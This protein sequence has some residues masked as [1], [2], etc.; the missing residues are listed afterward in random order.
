MPKKSSSDGS[1]EDKVVAAKSDVP[2]L[3][4]FVHGIRDPGFWQQKLRTMFEKERFV[5]VPIGYGVLDVFRFLLGFRRKSVET[6][7]TQILAAM[8]NNPGSQVTI[9]AHSFG[10]YA[11]ARLLEENPSI[12]IANLVMCGAIVKRGYRWDKTVNLNAQGEE[13][14]H[15]VNE[16]SARDV[17]P[18]IARHATFGFGDVGSIGCQDANVTDRRHNLPHSA[19]L[20]ESFAGD[21]WVGHLARGEKLQ[22]SEEP[23][24]TPWYFVLTRLP[25]TLAQAV[26]VVATT[27]AIVWSVDRLTFHTAGEL[28]I[29]SAALGSDFT[30]EGYSKTDSLVGEP[31]YSIV[32]PGLEGTRRLLSINKYDRIDV[33]IKNRIPLDCEIKLVANEYADTPDPQR[34]LS[35]QAVFSIS[36]RNARRFFGKAKISFEYIGSKSPDVGDF[37]SGAPAANDV[38]SKALKIDQLIIKAGD[39]IDYR[40]IGVNR[41][42]HAGDDCLDQTFKSDAFVRIVPDESVSRSWFGLLA[43]AQDS[44]GESGSNKVRQLLKSRDLQLRK[45]GV[46]TVLADPKH[47]GSDVIA[48]INSGEADI[49]TVADLLLAA[50]S[51]GTENIKLDPRTVLQLTYSDDNQVRD[52]ARS[53][54]RKPGIVSDDV[55][56]MAELILVDKLPW[57][58]KQVVEGKPFNKDYLLLIAVRDIYYNIGV[59]KLSKHLDSPTGSPEALRSALATF[60]RGDDLMALAASPEQRAT[61]SKNIYGRA[62]AEYRGAIWAAAI[63][64]GNPDAFLRNAVAE[65]EPLA[66]S[67]ARQTFASFLAAVGE[68]RAAYPWPHHIAQAERCV[69]DYTFSCFAP[70]AAEEA[71]LKP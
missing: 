11:V 28:A 53:Y 46:E 35:N 54:L 3:V 7:K 55:L 39:G 22:F 32:M 47:Y 48:V 29:D 69:A 15:V 6:V 58:Q 70:P 37:K 66:N 57:L 19:Y 68:H 45:I 65:N 36:L 2:R 60:A 13:R 31:L 10:T 20:K 12:E 62:M 17:W 49:K 1:I 64:S 9:I 51:A 41:V 42:K 27:L 59:D 8:Q 50:K 21:N 30:I 38:A 34:S 25:F 4:I 56:E 71:S 18:L 23:M 14:M 61:L 24:T 5:A 67:T 26:T 63:A 40:R 16:H 43:W 44:T 33:T 52:V